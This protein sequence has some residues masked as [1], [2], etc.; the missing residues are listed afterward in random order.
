MDDLRGALAK[1]PAVVPPAPP[2][3]EVAKPEVVAATASGDAAQSVAVFYPASTGDRRWKTR[4]RSRAKTAVNPA[5]ELERNSG[6]EPA[7]FALAK[8]SR[9]KAGRFPC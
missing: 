4:S 8:P 2:P 3:A 5:S 1:L 9:F 7:T 6:F